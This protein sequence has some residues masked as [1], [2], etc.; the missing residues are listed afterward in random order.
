MPKKTAPKLKNKRITAKGEF[1]L[2]RHI[3]RR[4]NFEVDAGYRLGGEKKHRKSFKTL[5]EAKTYAEQINIRLKNEG[6]SGF[7][8]TREE[9]IDAL[10]ALKTVKGLG[11]SLTDAAAFYAE[12]H[13][14]KGAEM[15][16]GELVDDHRAKLDDDRAK[17]EGVADRTYSDYKS[18]HNRL[19]DEFSSI[20]LI[21]F[22]H[23]EHWEAF[24]RK[25]GE[26][27]RRYENHLRILF[28]YAVER[29][30]L[31]SS[32]MIGKLSDA[33]K[34][35]K[36]AI[37]REDQWRQLLLTAIQTDSTLDL[38]GYV[39]LTLYMG[40][41]PESEVKRISW[42]NIN[43]KTGKL[44]LG[45]DE[46]GKSDLGRTLEIPKAA[47]DLLARCKRKKGRIIKSDYEH[48]KNW[49]E[50]REKAGFIVRNK[51]GKI[52][53]NDWVADIAR[54]TAGTMV[55]ANTQSKEV[56]R[57]FLGHTNDVTMRYYVNHGESLDEEAERFY[58]FS[59]PLPDLEAD[60]EEATG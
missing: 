26:A 21:A 25:L 17:G 49:D 5:E 45:D 34:L 10:K 15:T 42:K 29:G 37:L 31:N 24:S 41:R 2:I 9:Q 52:T 55:Y 8:L 54:H 35:N 38:L 28:N 60:L 18:R 50:L 57:A 58:S 19:K 32:P 1:P 22:S 36:P 23:I 14:L 16:F 53:R 6:L 20:K 39:V 7:K 11:V 13:Q 47:M 12:Y 30:Y 4:D 56:V 48:R 44:F 3:A 59:A 51:E 43:F 46:T 27:S 33:P 40:L